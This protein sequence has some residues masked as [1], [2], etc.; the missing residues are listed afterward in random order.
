LQTWNNDGTNRLEVLF[1]GGLFSGNQS[2]INVLGF[3]VKNNPDLDFLG[4]NQGAFKMD[5]YD[6]AGVEAL[7]TLSATLNGGPASSVQFEASPDGY[8]TYLGSYNSV[9]ATQI[10]ITGY[11]QA[12]TLFDLNP[13]VASSGSAVAYTLGTST[14]LFSGDKIL[15]LQNN[16][17][18]VATIEF[19]GAITAGSTNRLKTGP[20]VTGASVALTTTNYLELTINGVVK[21]VALVQ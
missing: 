4:G 11:N 8:T 14:N 5:F 17:T 13:T 19:D 16:T 1:N 18:N 6:N 20:I 21:K 3:E 10:H 2:P 12:G 7:A 15:A 9:N